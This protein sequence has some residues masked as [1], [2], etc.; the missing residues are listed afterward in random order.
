[1]GGAASQGIDA[2]PVVGTVP[3]WISKDNPWHPPLD[4][5]GQRTAWKNF[6]GQLVKR[7]KPDGEYWKKPEHGPS[8]YQRQFG[9]LAKPRPIKAYQI[10][11]EPNLGKYFPQDNA[12]KQ[13]AKLVKLAHSAIKG[14]DRHAKVVLAGMPKTKKSPAW[15][16]LKQLYHVKGFR[17]SFDVVALH[18][19]PESVHDLK[20]RIIKMRKVM[21]RAHDARTKLWITELGWGSA[22]PSHRW[23]INKGLKGQRRMLK[24]S[25]KLILKKRRSWHIGRVDWYNWRDPAPGTGGLCSFCSSSGLLYHNRA[26]KPSM[27]A[28]I[29]LTG[30][31]LP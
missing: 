22:H 2:Q 7:Y 28:W 27:S 4:T 13:Y 19:Y 11:N 31:K 8:L 9:P 26:P 29:H 24:S 14:N 25:F 16:F 20:V 3:Q 30:G 12:P 18:P 17:R 6:I 1:V 5:S 21:K 10:W 15:S 23:P